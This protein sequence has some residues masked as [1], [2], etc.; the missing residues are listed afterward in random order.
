MPVPVPSVRC[1]LAVLLILG[2]AKAALAQ[3]I[4]LLTTGPGSSSASAISGLGGGAH[5][6]TP[7]E[8][9]EWEARVRA[10]FV[11]SAEIG[12]VGALVDR[13]AIQTFPAGEPP[14][15]RIKLTPG[16]ARDFCPDKERTTVQHSGDAI[17]VRVPMGPCKGQ[18][19]RSDWS[20]DLALGELAPR[21]YRLRL[22]I[23]FP[24]DPAL[25]KAVLF[26]VEEPQP[27]RTLADAA[28]GSRF[29]LTAALAQRDWPQAELDYAIQMACDTRNGGHRWGRDSAESMVI[30]QRLLQAGANAQAG[31]VG[32]ARGNA[33]CI[34]VLVA[35]G[36]RV[37]AG[38]PNALQEAVKA[39]NDAGVEALLD[40]GANPNIQDDKG[41]SAYSLTYQH[42]DD[43]RMQNLRALMAARGGALSAGQAAS[44]GGKALGEAAHGLGSGLICLVGLC[45]H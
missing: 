5:R 7:A 13:G 41:Q 26:T 25:E 33:N 38:T 31:L 3:R 2:S 8:V 44:M 1:A 9:A 36:A 40:A 29:D 15:A 42:G 16:Y 23:E 4:E 20:F 21:R 24:G 18:G 35:A 10:S 6:L 11:E 17:D 22:V 43:S 39:F 30:A 19:P 37:D 14:Q 34:P 32:A 27:T 45:P 12:I 28:R